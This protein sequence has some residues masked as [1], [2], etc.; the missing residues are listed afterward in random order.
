MKLNFDYNQKE[1]S[2]YAKKVIGDTNFYVGLSKVCPI[3]KKAIIGYPAISRKDNKTE[4]CSNCGTFEA[5][6]SHYNYNNKTGGKMK[7]LNMENLINNYMNNNVSKEIENKDFISDT[8]N[9]VSVKLKDDYL[10]IR[11]AQAN[12]W[13]RIN[14][15]YKSGETEEIYRKKR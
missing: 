2:S 9:L 3:C 12:G 11:T 10:S 14:N 6:E 5:L 13:T 4:I 8:G 15:Y 1:N 7:I